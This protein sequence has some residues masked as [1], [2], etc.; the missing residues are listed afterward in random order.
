MCL[1]TV[2]TGRSSVEE[3]DD[4]SDILVNIAAASGAAA[5]LAAM[6]I[7]AARSILV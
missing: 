6:I 3:M 1:L 7:C 2:N 5:E 4:I